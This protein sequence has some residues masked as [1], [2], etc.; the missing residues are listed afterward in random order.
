MQ[1]GMSISHVLTS[2][3]SCD[4]DMADYVA[5]LAEEDSCG[6][7]ALLFEGMADP[8]RLMQAAE[9]AARKDKPLIVCKLAVGETGANAALSHTGSLAGSQAAYR[10][11]FQRAGAVLVDNFEHLMETASFFSKTSAPKSRGVAVLATSGGAAIMA[12]DKADAHGLSLPQPGPA[13]LEVLKARIPDFGSTANPFDATAQVI[14]DPDCVPDCARAILADPA[15]GALIVPTVFAAPTGIARVPMWNKLA[16]DSGKAVLNIWLTDWLEGPTAPEMEQ[17]PHAVLFRSMDRAFACIAAWHRRADL[18]AA[19]HDLPPDTPDAVRAQAA[20]LLAASGERTLTEREAKAVLAL[21]GIPVVQEHLAQSA[22]DAVRHAQATGYPVVVKVESP[23]LPHKT[24]AGVIRLNLRNEAELR[25]AYAAVMA[26]AAKV[27]PPPR[28]NGVL[29]QPMVPQG[30]EMMLG[31]RIDPLFGPII[32]AGLG[33]VLV[34]LMQDTAVGLAPVTRHEALGML[35][36]LKGQAALEGFRG[37]PA[38]DRAALADIICRLGRFLSDHA[39]LLAEIDINP[40][41]CAGGRILAVDA[42]IVKVE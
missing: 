16:Q 34:E 3:N 33:G 22:D 17:A 11:A 14:N 37:S 26:N 29:V 31:G 24:E 20:A 27:Q 41:I 13:A 35:A 39:A 40:L 19:P 38:V 5:Y 21:Y 42:W 1:R 18:L 32:L 2:G 30:T 8:V 25:D 10:T 12:A 23:D 7:I 36:G 6:A 15:Y 4:V 9:L 28:I